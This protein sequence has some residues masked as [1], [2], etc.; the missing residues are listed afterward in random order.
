ML[1][2][3]EFIEPSVEYVLQAENVE[4]K[5]EAPEADSDNAGSIRED[6][7]ASLGRTPIDPEEVRGL[8]TRAA[9]SGLDWEE[10]Y[11]AA[12]RSELGSRPFMAPSIPPACRV[13]PRG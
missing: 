2:L 11:D 1:G 13:A 3:Q 7:T 12:V 4:Q 10:M 5:E 8:L 6:L 9:R